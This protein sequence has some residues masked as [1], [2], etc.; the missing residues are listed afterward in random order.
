MKNRVAREEVSCADAFATTS[1][2]AA[3]L[4]QTPFQAWDGSDIM[5][6]YVG[7]DRGTWHLD[8]QI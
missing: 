1:Q 8:L 5:R 4:S 7:R 6:F 2:E 3:E